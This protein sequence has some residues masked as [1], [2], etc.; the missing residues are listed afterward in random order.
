FILPLGVVPLCVAGAIL[1]ARI[2]D[3]ARQALHVERALLIADAWYVVGPV[4]VL[5][6]AGQ[7]SPSLRH[8][9]L[10]VAALAAQ[11][12]FDFAATAIINKPGPLTPEERGIMNAHTI[13]GEQ[14]LE[15]VGGLLGEIGRLVR[16]CH[17]HYDGSGYP[18]GIAGEDIPL[19]ARIVCCCDAFHAMTSDRPYRKALSQ[20]VALAEL[21]ANSGTQ[22]DP[23]V[24]S[25]LT[26]VARR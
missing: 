2:I 18:D 17:E 7:T 4:V 15:Q 1:L 16:S 14:M 10:Y 5:A 26:A 11:F 3:G 9:P 13:E 20:D 23:Q 8:W 22:F 25:A 19:V 24:V 12:L 6:A 21:L